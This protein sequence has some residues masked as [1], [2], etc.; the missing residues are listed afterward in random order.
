LA[1]AGAPTIL[2]A[3]ARQRRG[4]LRGR[5]LPTLGALI[6][7]TLAGAGA[8]REVLERGAREGRSRIDGALADRR[9]K[10]LLAELGEVVLQLLRAGE[11]E[12]E[13]LPEVREL[14]ADLE[15]LDA[16]RRG[17]GADDD[18]VA[19]PA[20]RQRFDAR[21]PAR[22]EDDGTVASKTWTP[23]G[24]GNLGAPRGAPVWRPPTEPAAPDAMTRMV[25]KATR[26]GGITFDD[27]DLADYMHP[28]DVPAR[29]AS[30]GPDKPDDHDA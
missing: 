28:D 16:G 18:D 2:S 5:E 26:Q 25:E 9:R 3:M 11:I 29:A 30:P 17:G 1:K 6:K 22:D 23:P 10:D 24:R 12:L 8:V 27:D 21:R 15:D 7:N 19:R 20:S 13:E 14:V 4:G